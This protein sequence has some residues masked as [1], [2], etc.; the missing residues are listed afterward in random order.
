MDVIILSTLT[1][2]VEYLLLSSSINRWRKWS[3]VV[4]HSA[5]IH[6]PLGYLDLRLVDLYTATTEP[7]HHQITARFHCTQSHNFPIFHPYSGLTSQ[8][9]LRSLLNCIWQSNARHTKYCQW[10]KTSIESHA[11]LLL[12]QSFNW[13][14]ML[15]WRMGLI[16][17]YRGIIKTVILNHMTHVLIFNFAQKFEKLWCNNFTE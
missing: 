7:S 16:I 5:P 14:L 17:G 1:S 2:I 13:Y 3:S 12:C 11:S 4:R 8:S 6:S 9:S 10:C 15:L